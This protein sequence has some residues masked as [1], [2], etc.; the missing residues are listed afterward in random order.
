M[1][2]SLLFVTSALRNLLRNA[3][4]TL[5]VLVIVAGGT[6]AL[7]L[8]HGF[9]TGIMNQYRENAVH[10]FAGHGVVMPK[11]YRGQTFERP[12]EHWMTGASDVEA[13]LRRIPGV[14][15]VFPRLGVTGLLTNG[16]LTVAGRGLG[17]D[18][19]SEASFFTGLNV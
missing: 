9:N 10:A 13:R 11:G 5:A 2:A 8:Y 18:G 7:Y 1:S 12:W 6:S 17:V 4:R 14:T 16:R 15:N 3:R 19:P